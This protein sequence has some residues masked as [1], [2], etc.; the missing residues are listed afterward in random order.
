MLKLQFSGYY[1][2]LSKGTKY[3]GN[4]EKWRRSPPTIRPLFGQA[5]REEEFQLR[6]NPL[7][8]A[9]KEN[10]GGM[11]GFAGKSWEPDIEIEVPFEQRPVR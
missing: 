5:R 2:S 7:L 1:R 4:K 3:E 9:M 8:M 11:S 10:D 6:F